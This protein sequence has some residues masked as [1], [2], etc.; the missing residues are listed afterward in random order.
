MKKLNPN[1]V[2]FYMWIGI[3]FSLCFAGIYACGHQFYNIIKPSNI[4]VVNFL[5]QD[6]GLMQV[7]VHTDKNGVAN[8]V[9]FDKNEKPVYTEISHVMKPYDII[10]IYKPSLKDEIN[11]VTC[12]Q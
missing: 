8:C 12:Y 6:D 11:A 1:D 2:L 7:I 4:S 9:F 3:I 5:Q 10:E